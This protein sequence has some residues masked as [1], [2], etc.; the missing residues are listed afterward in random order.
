MALL[1]V[2]FTTGG[3]GGFHGPSPLFGPV[4]LLFFHGSYF[5]ENDFLS[6][7]KLGNWVVE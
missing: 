4:L 6:T 2:R 3:S 1:E 5:A 7:S